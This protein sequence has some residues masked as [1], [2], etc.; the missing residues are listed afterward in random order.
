[1]EDIYK[2]IMEAQDILENLDMQREKLMRE[3]EN[4]KKLQEEW[5]DKLDE[6]Y[7]MEAE[8]QEWK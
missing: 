7:D 6:L 4:V 2:R 8:E 1:M 3:I 5:L